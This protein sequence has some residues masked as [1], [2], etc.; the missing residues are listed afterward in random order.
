MMF[1]PGADDL[2]LMVSTRTANFWDGDKAPASWRPEFPEGARFGQFSYFCQKFIKIFLVAGNVVRVQPPT[3]KIPGEDFRQPWQRQNTLL[4]GGVK[5]T[6][7]PDMLFRPE[8]IHGASGVWQPFQPAGEGDGHISRDALR[9][10]GGY[11]AILHFH[12][13]RQAAV[14]TGSSDLHRLAR[15]EPA[16]SQRLEASLGEPFLFTRHGNAVL[17]G[18]VAEGRKAADVVRIRKQPHP[19]HS[20]RHEFMEGPFALIH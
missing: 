16:Y 5:L 13:K 7:A 9:G 19:Q 8:E 14:K 18:K 20:G 12:V 6:P 10:G 3:E 2:Q 15:E 4:G 11:L 1:Y 17:G